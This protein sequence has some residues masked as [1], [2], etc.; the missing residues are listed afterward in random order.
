M[1]KLTNISKTF[2]PGKITERIALKGIDFEMQDG[3][4]VTVIG[5]NGAGKSTLLNLIAGVHSADTGSLVLDGIDL[6][7]VPEHLRAKYLGRVFQDPM[8]G[9][10]ADMQIEENLALAMRRGKKRGLSWGIHQ[11]ERKLYREKLALLDLGLEN[12]MTSKVGLLSGGQR[13]ALTLLMATLQKPRLLL[14]DEH[15]AALDPKTAK[16][17]LE[18]TEQ[19]IKAD[20]LSAFMVTHNMKNAIHYGNRLIMMREGRIIF[21]VRGEEKKNLKVEDLLK[22]FGSAGIDGDFNDRMILN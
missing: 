20:N 1:L 7:N 3:D 21:D 17:V 4:F 8:R 11:S 13:Q 2:N 15:T 18:L 12:R 22:K 5:G 9:T 19:F 6:T 10:A 16:K 14:L